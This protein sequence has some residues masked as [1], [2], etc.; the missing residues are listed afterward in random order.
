MSTIISE[1]TRNSWTVRIDGPSG[2]DEMPDILGSAPDVIYNSDADEAWVPT[3]DDAQWWADWAAREE[4]INAS[5]DEMDDLPEAYVSAIADG[6]D[7]DWAN[8]QRRECE[9]LGIDYGSIRGDGP[10]VDPEAWAESVIDAA[11]EAGDIPEA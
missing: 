7:C 9:A 4:A 1:S 6:V 3:D 10:D 11:A 5:L 2:Q 8:T